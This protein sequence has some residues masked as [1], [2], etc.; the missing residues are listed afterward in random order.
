MGDLTAQQ[1]RTLARS[2]TAALAT[3]VAGAALAGW[4]WQST[5]EDRAYR[6]AVQARY[7]RCLLDA[8][9]TD[10]GEAADAVADRCELVR[11]AALD[12]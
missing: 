11:D 4:W 1:H 10:Y 2:A 7:E 9:V 3:F 8:V 5:A 6:D 12:R